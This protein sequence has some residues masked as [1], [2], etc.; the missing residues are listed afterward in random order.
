MVKKCICEICTCG[1]HRCPHRPYAGP[2]RGDE[3]CA[4]SEYTTKYPAH[5]VQLRESFKPQQV[6]MT[7]EGP[8]ADKTTHRVDYVPYKVEK[9][10][11]KGSEEYKKPEGDM[12][13]LTSYKQTYTGK[14][15]TPP[16]AIRR[17]ATKSLPAKFEGEPTYRI[18]YRKWP[19]TGRPDKFGQE[20]DWQPPTQ[21]FEGVS[22]F[23][24]DYR[25]YNE[26]PRQSMRPTEAAK[27]SDAPIDDHTSYR[28]SYIR[29]PLQ[30]KWA[31]EKEHY[32][33]TGVP[34]DGLSTFRRDYRGQVAPRM[35]SCKP[36]AQAFQSDKPLDSMT[37]FRNDY[38]K[39]PTERP[40]Q[41][42]PDQYVKPDGDFDMN[43]THKMQFRQFPIQRSLAKKP[44]DAK[45]RGGPF[46]GTTNYRQDY[47]KWEMGKI[48]RPG[49]KNDYVASGAPFEGMSTHTAHFVPHAIPPARS[50]KP[51]TGAVQSDAPFE[52]GTMYRIDYTPK[53]SEP[54]PAGLLDTN[55][56]RYVYRETAT[57]GHKFYQPIIE[58]VTELPRPANDSTQRIA[59]L[60]VA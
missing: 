26:K 10:W 36:D 39:W 43:T 25:R 60:S 38:R 9:P 51:V 56:S 53:R 22:T 6:P 47:K 33:P 42:Q 27:M 31:K 12:E 30:P 57:T 5:P 23:T 46:D 11:K 20:P 16:K 58:T 29:H 15:G 17:D 32:K 1:R 13:T 40:H 48:N 55:T 24:D 44:D 52:D 59:A 34:F 3:P 4:L 45:V 7:G 50:C 18:D 35:E 54:C 2:T 49:A 21:R 37:T 8:I 41:H 28:E 14:Y 19:M